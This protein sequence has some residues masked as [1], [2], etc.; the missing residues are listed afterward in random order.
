[1][2][3]SEHRNLTSLLNLAYHGSPAFSPRDLCQAISATTAN[4][5]DLE[6]GR[7]L[8]GVTYYCLRCAENPIS[9][10]WASLCSRCLYR[11]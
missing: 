7:D 11:P 2:D 4:V 3:T 8:L 10:P 5:I 6:R 9:A 1:M